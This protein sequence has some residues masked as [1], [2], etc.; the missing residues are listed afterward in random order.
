MKSGSGTNIRLADVAE[1]AKV[2]IATVSRALSNPDQVSKETRAVVMKAAKE[3]GYRVNRAA[4]NLRKRQSGEV[5]VLVPNLGNPFFSKILAGIE[6]TFSGSEYNVLIADSLGKDASEDSLTEY[7]LSSH[8]DGIIVLDGQVSERAKEWL[9]ENAAQHNVVFACEW[10]E[11]VEVPIVR[12]NNRRGAAAAI[13]Y[14]HS[15]GHRKIAHVTGPEHNV[16]T[17]FRHEGVEEECKRLGLPMHSEWMIRGDFSMQ[18]GYQAAEQILDMSER[19]TCVFCTSDQMACG[20]ISRL[21]AEGIR[22]PQDISVMGF[23]DIELAEFYVPRLTTIRQNRGQLGV[24]AA[25]LV[26]ASLRSESNTGLPLESIID[27]ELVV[28]DSCAPLIDMA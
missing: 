26:L 27:V 11:D 23:D 17:H 18:S 22:V 24:T 3:T 9:R 16:L 1:A 6:E 2:S 8:A 28:R 15:L 5:L 21:H 13:R 20:V 19:P 25:Q 14:L 10:V 7:L 4:R 12:S